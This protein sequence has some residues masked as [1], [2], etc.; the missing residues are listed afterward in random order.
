MLDQASVLGQSFSRE[1]LNVLCP[2]VDDLGEAL[3]ALVRV[4]LLRQES[5]RLSAERGQYQFVQSAVRQA[6]YGMLSRRDR[7]ASHLAVIAFLESGD[8]AAGE[9]AAILA[10]HH[11]EA[12]DAAP[13]A[14]DAARLTERAVVHLRA[15]AARAS[16]LGAP[17]EAAG[18]LETALTRCDEPTLHAELRTD[19]A[20]QLARAGQHERAIEHA[21]A[22]R[23]AYDA[24]GDQVRAG[25]AVALLAHSMVVGRSEL[26]A[27]ES[28]AQ[29][30][31]ELVQGREEA[32]AVELQLIGAVVTA[33]LRAGADFHEAAMREVRLADRVGDASDIAGSYMTLALHYVIRGPHALGRILLEHAA[34]MAREARDAR[35]LVR[36]LTN[37][38]ANLTQEDA[39]RAVEC[40]QDACRAAAQL[41]DRS[42]QSNSAV[43]LL[44]AQFVLGDWD[45]ALATL[46]GVAL[47]RGERPF[48]E[49][50]RGTLLVA[51]G[52]SWAPAERVAEHI[53][54]EPTSTGFQMMIMALSAQQSGEPA[55]ASALAVSACRSLFGVSGLFDDFTLAWCLATDMVHQIG[56]RA[57]LDQLF[58]VVAADTVNRRPTGL[59]TQH[60]RMLGLMAIEDGAAPEVVEEHLR[61]AIT[62]ARAW[63]SGVW[64][65]KTQADLG[66]WLLRQG[67]DEEAEQLLGEAGASF[68]LFGAD[69]WTRSLE[70]REDRVS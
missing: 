7:K 58:A 41:G 70:A 37:L 65:A 55:R 46:D 66:D 17:A 45:G 60:S 10:Q 35:L 51:R 9:L 23:D 11:L 6:A 61:A 25:R 68:D 3:A 18:H 48:A 8:E 27:A 49:L 15:A 22:A 69:A 57:A 43:N 63:R 67:R 64:L 32:A 39:A 59:R 56:D 36:A 21:S 53:E 16:G 24:L 26:E 30:R 44:M 52:L 54:E 1:S 5:G 62:H 13:E 2:D 28:L 14:A 42:W 34:D 47:D 40:G 50:V 4:Q 33:R 38:N 12:I 29:E 20:D 19:L 31:L